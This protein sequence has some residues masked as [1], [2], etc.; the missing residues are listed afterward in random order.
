MHTALRLID[1]KYA[2]EGV[3][4]V[5]EGG[6]GKGGEGKKKKGGRNNGHY[7]RWDLTRKTSAPKAR[8]IVGFGHAGVL[9]FGG[10]EKFW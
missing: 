8:A 5:G 9:N 4:D 10:N 6:K 1:P 3:A 2:R 7:K